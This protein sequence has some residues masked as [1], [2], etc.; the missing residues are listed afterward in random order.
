M[1][2]HLDIHHFTNIYQTLWSHV[3]FLRYDAMQQTN[4][5]KKRLIELDAPSKNSIRNVLDNT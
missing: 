3:R 5:Q 2:K 4:R 1:K